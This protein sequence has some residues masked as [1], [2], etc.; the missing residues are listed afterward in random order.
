MR[1]TGGLFWIIERNIQKIIIERKILW[2]CY[3][4]YNSWVEYRPISRFLNFKLRPEYETNLKILIITIPE[5]ETEIEHKIPSWVWVWDLI[6]ITT[7]GLPHSSLNYGASSSAS[8]NATL[9]PPGST[10]ED[11]QYPAASVSSKS[12]FFG[13]FYI[14]FFKRMNTCRKILQWYSFTTNIDDANPKE[15]IKVSGPFVETSCVF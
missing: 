14:F 13:P 5:S 2:I 8:P 11:P 1:I 4:K 15:G 10:L 7:L 12:P 9:P 3:L 6:V